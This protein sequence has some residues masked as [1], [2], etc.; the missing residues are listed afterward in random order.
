MTT[1]KT[2]NNIELIVIEV[3][4]DAYDFH[5]WGN[6][7][8][9]YTEKSTDTNHNIAS[10]K[11]CKILGKLLELSEEECSRF[12]EF[13]ETEKIYKNYIGFL[14][15]AWDCGNSA[16]ESFISLLQSQGVDT[17]KHLLLIEKI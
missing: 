11:N 15:Q 13:Y 7:V 10:F 4:E 9:S 12:V 8:L 1:I 14:D 5:I 6:D 17:S 2:H 16:K 3:P